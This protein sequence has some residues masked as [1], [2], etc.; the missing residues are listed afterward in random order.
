[1]IALAVDVGKTFPDLILTDLSTGRPTIR[2]TPST[3]RNPAH[4]IVDGQSGIFDI[5]GVVPG[6]IDSTPVGT[7]AMRMQAGRLLPQ[8]VRRFFGT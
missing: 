3:P 5:A 2:K 1:M 6:R 8:S 7:G 4:R